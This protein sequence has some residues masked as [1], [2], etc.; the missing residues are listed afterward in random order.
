MLIVVTV[1]TEQLPVAPI[2]RIV[3]VVVVLVMD[4]ELAQLLAVKFASAV[5]TDPRKYF[6]R[7]LSIGLL[8]LSLGSPCHESLEEDDDS[9][10]RDYTF[11]QPTNMSCVQGQ[12][13]TRIVGL[14][15]PACCASAH[16]ALNCAGDL[17]TLSWF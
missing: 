8:Q 13:N 12:E 10:W 17:V 3:V 4:R 14:T 15:H 6:E 2:G 1:E 5:P 16:Q 11:R 7:L 9:V